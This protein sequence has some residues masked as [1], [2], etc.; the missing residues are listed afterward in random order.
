MRQQFWCWCEEGDTLAA[1]KLRV[2]C[3]QCRQ[4]AVLLQRDPASWGDIG[5][6]LPGDCQHC[7]VGQDRQSLGRV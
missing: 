5:S 2:R 6:G 1:A 4:D 3:Q 7:K